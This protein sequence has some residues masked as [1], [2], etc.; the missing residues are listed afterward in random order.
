[1]SQDGPVRQENLRW[2]EEQI[3]VTKPCLRFLGAPGL[4]FAAIALL[5][6]RM[7]CLLV[8][9]CAERTTGHAPRELWRDMD[10]FREHVIPKL[11]EAHRKDP[12]AVAKE[13]WGT[14]CLSRDE[15]QAL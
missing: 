4:L 7:V 10:L 12:G 8:L 9:Q 13:F 1:M 6:S 14:F 15:D 2:L 11:K 5:Q 3:R